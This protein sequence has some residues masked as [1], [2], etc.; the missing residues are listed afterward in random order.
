[1]TEMKRS[2]RPNLSL[3]PGMLCLATLLLAHGCT[4]PSI[5]RGGFESAAPAART[6]AIEETVRKARADG[7]LQRDDLKQ[8]VSLLIADDSM[9]RF[10]AI[11][12]L[13][14]LTNQDFGY[15]F[16]DSPEIRFKSVLRWRSYALETSG[17]DEIKVVPPPV[18]PSKPTGKKR[19]KG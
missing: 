18:E 14:E 8:M 13:I 7:T 5:T 3:M 9:V 1:M 6:H 4:A 2:P 10:M 16:F 17:T 15:R 12:G 11:S 19:A